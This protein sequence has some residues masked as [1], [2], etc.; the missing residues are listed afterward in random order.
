MRDDGGWPEA[1]GAFIGMCLELMFVVLVIWAL[2][3][4]VGCV[5]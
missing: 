3:K 2:M 4:Y 1:I 5:G